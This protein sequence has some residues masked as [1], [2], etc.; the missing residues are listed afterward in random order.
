MLLLQSQGE[1]NKNIPWETHLPCTLS[2]CGKGKCHLLQG[3]PHPLLLLCREHTM[4]KA[5]AAQRQTLDLSRNF[6][7]LPLQNLPWSAEHTANLTPEPPPALPQQDRL[8][9]QPH[10]PGLC[11]ASS[12]KAAGISLPGLGQAR[13]RGCSLSPE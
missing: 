4:C 5:K 12:S 13:P 3:L 7:H 9:G 11:A 6:S 8:Q 10:L 1:N 2:G